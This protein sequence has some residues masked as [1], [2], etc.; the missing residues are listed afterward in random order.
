MRWFKKHA[1]LLPGDEPHTAKVHRLAQLAGFASWRALLAA[2]DS[3][4]D[5]GIKSLQT[6]KTPETDDER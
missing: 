1:K 6:Y 3:E 2:T 4:R 5:A